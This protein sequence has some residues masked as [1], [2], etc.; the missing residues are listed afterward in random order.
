[1]EFL[2]NPSHMVKGLIVE[3][4]KVA[5]TQD[6]ANSLA[7]YSIMEGDIVMARRGEMGRCAKV[8]AR[9]SGWLCGT[10]S[11]V[12]RFHK[13]VSRDFILLL[14]SSKPVVEYLSGASVGTTMTNLNHGILNKMPINLPPSA[15]QNRIV[16][17]VNELMALCDQL[18][19]SLAYA[20]ETQLTFANSIGAG[21]L[22]SN[23]QIPQQAISAGSIITEIHARLI[24]ILQSR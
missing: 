23:Q 6:K 11:F 3:D 15:E 13:S 22:I 21:D 9:E 19:A 18:K 10:G 5:V 14:F 24:R 17:K 2:I 20:Q 8:T 16:K 12:L 7:A 4:T 1:M